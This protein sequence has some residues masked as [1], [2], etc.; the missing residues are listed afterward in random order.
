MHFT[1]FI[2][3]IVFCLTYSVFARSAEG[4][5]RHLLSDD[6]DPS[7]I[8]L[9]KKGFKTNFQDGGICINDNQCPPYFYRCNT[10]KGVTKVLDGQCT[11]AIW[12]WVL[13]GLLCFGAVGACCCCI[14]FCGC[15]TKLR[16]LAYRDDA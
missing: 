11:L 12:V 9:F 7:T 1:N 3:L 10:R 5:N 2:V 15:L 14:C 4:M 8:D 16:G 13:I 6:D